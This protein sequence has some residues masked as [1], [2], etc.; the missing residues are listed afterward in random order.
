MCDIQRAFKNFRD[1]IFPSH[2]GIVLE[3][4][5]GGYVALGKWCPNM[6]EVDLLIDEHLKK[7]SCSLNRIK[8][9]NNEY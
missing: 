9:P 6:K 4:K 5:N 8:I 1:G 7:L 2:R 3:R